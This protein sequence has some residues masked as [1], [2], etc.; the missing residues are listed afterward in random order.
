M[1]Q[2]LDSASPDS[3]APSWLTWMRRALVC[4]EQAEREGEVP[5]GALVVRDGEILG[6]G[7]NLTLQ[8]GDPTGHAEIVALRRAAARV[9]NHRLG[10][11]TLITTLEP[12]LMCFGAI[13]ECRI[14]VVVYGAADPLRGAV[15]LWKSG[16]L[17]RYPVGDLQVV[18]GVAEAECTAQLKKWFAGRRSEPP[19]LRGGAEP[20]KSSFQ[21]RRGA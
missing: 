7:S 3:P 21:M 19:D 2:A 4:A 1:S 6:E 13:L 16:A 15:P 18:A 10:G 9:R 12:C 8:L 5:V 14:A 20:A 11:A 17:S